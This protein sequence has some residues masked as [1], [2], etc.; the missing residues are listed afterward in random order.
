MDDDLRSRR[1]LLAALLTAMLA[2]ADGSLVSAQ[3]L[4]GV[5]QIQYQSVDRSPSLPTT[6]T[7][8]KIFQVDYARR[9]PGAIDLSSSFR[10]IEQTVARQSDRLRAPEGRLRLAHRNFGVTT[11]YRPTEIRDARGIFT[12]QQSLDVTGYL[13]KEGLPRLTGSW[14]RSHLDSS[15]LSPASATVTRAL[16]AQYGIPRLNVHAGYGDRSLDGPSETHP[17]LTDS[18]FTAGSSS[19]FAIGR[20]PIS[21]QYDFGESRSY[22]TSSRPVLSRTHTAG[23]STGFPITSRTST[24]FSYNY[25]RTEIPA[26]LGSTQE[27]NGALSLAHVLSPVVQLAAGGGVRSVVL[28]ARTQ[29]EEYASASAVAQGEARPG[30]RISASASHAVSWLPGTGPRASDGFESGTAMRLTR[31]LDVRGNFAVSTSRQVTS[32]GLLGPR[33]VGVQTGG[34]IAAYPLRA[35]F[36][37]GSVARSRSGASLFGAGT[38]STSYAAGMRLTPNP[39]MQ[40]SG[41]WGLTVAPGSRGSSF[42]TSAQL[43]LR[44]SFQLSGAYSRSRQEITVPASLASRQESLAG[45][46]TMALARDL[47]ASLQYSESNRGKPNRVRQL[48]I[49]V[50]HT[51]GR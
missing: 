7:W 4:H 49:N 29:T 33:Q 50:V 34:G 24:A 28:G 21:V 41:R 47:N 26:R 32:D 43:A 51:F 3:T 45:A 46:V 2:V 13:Q 20:A 6:D 11:G 22:P 23:A 9:L 42:Q 37:D 31:G 5:T 14:V 16:S 39:R 48:T 15:L 19:Q 30:L 36:L 44:S 27:H 8:A 38:S 1:R 18:H 40:T 17:R 12:R 10:F 35:L 25:H